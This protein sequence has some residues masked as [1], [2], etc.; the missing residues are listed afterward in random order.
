MAD[1][2]KTV[3]YTF[4]VNVEKAI[5]DAERFRE[6]INKA[7]KD[8]VNLAKDT[9]T[10]LKESAFATY[11][12][13]EKQAIAKYT[14]ELGKLNKKGF[15]RQMREEQKILTIALSEI[16]KEL[17]T[18][19]SAF[20]KFD[21]IVAKS[22]DP[23][24]YREAVDR[25]KA[26]LQKLTTTG[27]MSLT[28]A[29]EA[30]RYQAISQATSQYKATLQELS[31][32]LQN[33]KIST[34]DY[35]RSIKQAE[36]VM[37]SQISTA[38]KV[39]SQGLKE[40]QKE[41][42]KT[43]S[44]L[45]GLKTVFQAV[46]GFSLVSIFRNI[47]NYF[48]E[49]AVNA[50][51]LTQS[52][53][54]L[55][56]SIRS[57]QKRGLD[58]TI[59]ETI[60]QIRELR[61]EFSFFTTKEIADGIGQIQL[62]TR[63][64]GF[65]TTQMQEMYEIATALALI[66]GKDLNEASR[67]LALFYSSGYAE[68][69]QR[70]GIAVN[71]I[72]VTEEAWRNGIKKSY[73]ELSEQER[74][75]SAHNLVLKQ[76]KD[77]LEE[78]SEFQNEYIGQIQIATKTIEEQEDIIGQ[79]L[80]PT[81]A[82]WI[83]LK[84]LLLQTIT[85]TIQVLTRFTHGISV[86]T[87]FQ[88]LQNAIMATN[89]ALTSELFYVLENKAMPS[90]ER[91]IGRYD[92]L[93][94]EFQKNTQNRLSEF[95]KET[96]EN[97]GD[98]IEPVQIDA[99]I[100][101]TGGQTV[102]PEDK[103][104]EDL[105]ERLDEVKEG[106][107]D[108]FQDMNESILD[109]SSDLYDDLGDVVQIGEDGLATI[110]QQGL[111]K[112]LSIF[113]RY[114]S[115]LSAVGVEGVEN[116]L[117][118]EK[119]FLD[120]LGEID[121][122]GLMDLIDIWD[123]YYEELEDI[124]NKADQN[125]ADAE[126][127]LQQKLEDLAIDTQRKLED[128]ARKYR[129]EEI[130]AEQ[131]FQEKLRRLREKF[132]FDLEDAL[133]ERDAKQVLRLIRRYNLEKEQLE[134]EGEQEK[135]DREDKY[136]QEIEDIYRQAERKREAYNTDF[137]RRLADIQL[138]AE[139]EREEAQRERDRAYQE[140]LDDLE[141]ERADRVEKYDETLED[142]RKTFEEKI[143]DIIEKQFKDFTGAT[144]ELTKEITNLLNGAFGRNSMSERIFLYLGNSISNAVAGAIANI[145]LLQ[146]MAAQVAAYQA[147][148][149]QS[150]PYYDPGSYNP[151]PEGSPYLD[152]NSGFG[153]AEGGTIIAKKPTT[154]LFGEKGPEVATFIPLNKLAS[155]LESVGSPPSVG[156][157]AIGSGKMTVE[158]FLSPDLE[159]RVMDNTLNAAGEEILNILG[160]TK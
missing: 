96:S 53:Y 107:L 126:L 47:V 117:E 56:V 142:I 16:Q 3:E 113:D 100:D 15:A 7:K 14:D 19:S 91:V 33:N 10:S 110:D 71:K 24:K 127:D 130:K 63:N 145:Q 116:S 85:S 51:E 17:S 138:Q 98:F 147:P 135:Q 146:Q 40:I 102:F 97:F 31:T 157:G 155:V 35:A 62:L 150:N 75:Q 101:W 50:V 124:Q 46:F 108:A 89:I 160:V 154:A 44:A 143:Q 125:V 21:Q 88:T 141:K 32:A 38:K 93:M 34:D 55:G 137:Q 153:M 42:A 81:Y 158:I 1:R 28:D 74:A 105:Q 6:E 132:L 122:D 22:L 121:E 18:A 2:N 52:M 36:G 86:L 39:V 128:A 148:T 29:G 152:W 48:K 114:N 59:A 12:D 61:K 13:K 30:L 140:L 109:A 37:N 73:R 159:M 25:I 151:S 118:N 83:K 94:E 133:R 11:L 58:V 149:P 79:K 80:L 82:E 43:S 136:K 70:A 54:K 49:L 66:Q 120:Q 57:L 90:L 76:S 156:S 69:L 92:M 60:S 123:D 115:L 134:R 67:E 78:V 119:D 26:E 87:S 8:I 45:D 144:D 64:F 84:A 72:A 68:S 4:I 20:M 77:L 103:A 9:N 131:D 139:R 112:R 104:A 99:G 65:T 5:S 106:A 111:E 129:E 23:Q 95:F 27:G 41:T